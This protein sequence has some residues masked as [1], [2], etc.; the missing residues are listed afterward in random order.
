MMLHTYIHMV[1]R[2][3]IPKNQDNLYTEYKMAVLHECTCPLLRGSAFVGV[4]SE[5]T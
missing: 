2:I 1:V 5:T 4:A 3:E